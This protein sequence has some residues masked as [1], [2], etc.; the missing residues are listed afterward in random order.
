[1]KKIPRS[2]FF[3]S[4]HK[5]K[6]EN[7]KES[8]FSWVRYFV[9]SNPDDAELNILYRQ[10]IAENIYD[11]EL[12]WSNTPAFALLGNIAKIDFFFW[13]SKKKEWSDSISE[14]SK[15]LGKAVKNTAYLD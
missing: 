13:D 12:D 5:R 14:E 6:Y 2:F 9:A 4:A 11:R 15:Y 10:E 7:E 1:M 3:T 8:N